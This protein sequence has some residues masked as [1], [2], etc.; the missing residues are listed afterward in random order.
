[1]EARSAMKTTRS[2]N[3]IEA[4]SESNRFADIRALLPFWL[5]MSL[6]GF[7]CAPE[8]T[9]RQFTVPQMEFGPKQSDPDLGLGSVSEQSEGDLVPFRVNGPTETASILRTAENLLWL[10]RAKSE[11]SR[12]PGL[13]PE[14]RLLLARAGRKISQALSGAPGVANVLPFERSPYVSAATGESKAQVMKTLAEADSKLE[15]QAILLGSLLTD[16]GQR[17]PWPTENA[18]APDLFRSARGFVDQYSRIVSANPRIDPEVRSN[19]LD[20]LRTQVPPMIDNAEREIA[21]I[22]SEPRV[23]VLLQRFVEFLERNQIELDSDSREMIQRAQAVFA[24]VERIGTAQ[25]ALGALVD[26]WLFLTPEARELN[27]KPVSPDLY[28]FFLRRS[29]GDFKCLRAFGCL[30]PIMVTAKQVKILPELRAYGVDRMK[31]DVARAGRSGAI[32]EI[33]IRAG[34]ILP[35]MPAIVN[36]R[37]AQEFVKV[38]AAVK[39]IRDDYNGFIREITDKFARERLGSGNS[40]RILGVEASQVQASWPNGRLEVKGNSSSTRIV[41]GAETIGASLALSVAR[42]TSGFADASNSPIAASDMVSQISKVLALGGFTMENDKSFPS[43][44]ISMERSPKR[45]HVNLRAV[46]GDSGS[47]AV[48]DALKVAPDFSFEEDEARLTS[49][50]AQAELLRG[51]SR[52]AGFLRDWDKNAF[53]ETLGTIE[54][55]DYITRVPAQSVRQKLFPKELMF[56]A[57]VGN[58]A[59]VLQNLSKALTPMFLVGIDGKTIWSDEFR[60]KK[61]ARP[62]TM[63]GVVDVRNGQRLLT[64]RSRDV[65]RKLI[66]LIEFLE[67][68]EGVEKSTAAPLIEVGENGERAL[69]SLIEARADLK[70]AVLALANFLSHQMQDQDGGIR[71]TFVVDAVTTRKDEPRALMDQVLAIQALVRASTLLGTDV[72]KW[73]ALDALAFMNRKLWDPSR[74]FYR[75][76]EGSSTDRAPGTWPLEELTATLVAGEWLLPHLNPRSR[77]QWE[78]ISG[79]WLLALGKN[80]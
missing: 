64:S 12:S 80:Q 71:A 32:R 67:A 76:V 63:G 21:V 34:R 5:A 65:A 10:G 9:A 53:D 39:S 40:G 23:V 78:R 25:D 73:S 45:K 54:V 24:S 41:T 18:T 26:L 75:S 19:V 46:L 20:G 37:I 61:D 77:A 35:D 52:L 62:A 47:Y 59:V 3:G 7:G 72:Y 70:L 16:L 11:S 55:R 17:Y 36:L 69:D 48:P 14:R 33:E 44:A 60:A 8:T 66:A 6:V 51:L 79:P 31:Q 29:P 42:W 27:F 58:A 22:F 13:A 57:S 2:T 50:E 15:R 1:M 38:R 68:T 28:D 56:A 43:L 74:S 49:A 30:D 4:R